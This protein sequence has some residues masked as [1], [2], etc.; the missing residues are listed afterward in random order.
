MQFG[1]SRFLD[2]RSTEKYKVHVCVCLTCWKIHVQTVYV[3]QICT[4]AFTHIVHVY[5]FEPIDTH[6]YM[7]IITIMITIIIVITRP[8]TK[9]IMTCRHVHARPQW[10]NVSPVKKHNML[11]EMISLDL[12]GHLFVEDR[13]ISCRI[14]LKMSWR[15]QV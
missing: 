7:L 13:E 3:A 10:N 15:H 14:C 8:R 12:Q 4:D 5:L 9:M 11:T 2:L 1:T 6:A